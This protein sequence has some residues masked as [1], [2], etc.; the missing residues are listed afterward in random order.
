M[1][2]GFCL[3]VFLRLMILNLNGF[4]VVFLIIF[5]FVNLVVV[6]LMFLSFLVGYM[7]F[8][9]LVVGLRL[10]LFDWVVFFL[11]MVWISLLRMFSFGWWIFVRGWVSLVSCWI[12]C[13]NGW[14]NWG[15]L[16]LWMWR[17]RFVRLV[18]DVFDIFVMVNV[19]VGVLWF[20]VEG[21]DI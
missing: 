4:I 15:R 11:M 6:F 21:F 18:I 14:S 3:I 17:R 2:L 19:I 12:V 8:W 16:V 1:Y 10:M 20:V 5:M 13:M 7:R 9:I